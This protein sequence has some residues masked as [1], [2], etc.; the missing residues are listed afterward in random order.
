MLKFY[1]YPKCSTCKKAQKWLE[2]HEVAYIYYDIVTQTP[3]ANEIKSIL[4]KGT[5]PLKYYF[6]TSGQHYREQNLKE[7]LAEMDIDEISQLLSQDGMLL[8]RPLLMDDN[9]VICG[10]KENIYQSE[11][12]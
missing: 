4:T 9:E 6:N 12:L 5:H 7:R 1:C 8:K 10:F 11:L 2:E 3:S